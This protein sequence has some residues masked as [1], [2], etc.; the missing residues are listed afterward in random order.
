MRHASGLQII[1]HSAWIEIVVQQPW[2]GAT[3]PIKYALVKGN[4]T[5]PALSGDYQKVTIPINA[6]ASTS[7]T[8]LT[9]FESLGESEALRGFANGAYVYSATFRER[10]KSGTTREIG[11]GTG[12]NLEAC[13]ALKPDVLFTFSMGNDRTSHQRLQ[14]AG[15]QILY[16]ADYLESTPLGRA[17]WIKFTGAFFDKL[18]L[19]DSVFGVVEQNYMELKSLASNAVQRPSVLTGVVYGDTWFLP[20]GKNYGAEF[21][22]DAGAN[23]LWSENDDSGWLELSFESVY[24]KAANADYWIGVASFGSRQELA[25]QEDRYRLFTAWADEKIYN[26][27][28]LL[29]ENG[30]NNYLEEGYS[31]PDL[32][33]QDLIYILHPDLLPGHELYFYRK[34][35]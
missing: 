33:L 15:I 7:T 17:E 24:S 32:V 18:D 34:L 11:D 16:N 30:G 4:E 31:R 28:R 29:N 19:A 35:P 20:G 22:K 13:L 25:A 6:A 27:D 5:L 12:V 14:Q 8:H 2:Q 23:Y 3:K 26:Y 1:R 9:H 10:L 21:F